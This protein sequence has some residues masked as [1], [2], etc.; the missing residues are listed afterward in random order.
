V[1]P[2]SL[3]HLANFSVWFHVKELHIQCLGHQTKIG[4]I[5]WSLV[6]EIPN[7]EEQNA[8]TSHIIHGTEEEQG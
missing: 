1:P 6:Y 5:L 7:S 2:D 3:G 4:I 8:K